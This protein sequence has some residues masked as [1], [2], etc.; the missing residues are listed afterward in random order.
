MAFLKGPFMGED[1]L[2]FP[3]LSI[4]FLLLYFVSENEKQAAAVNLSFN[5]E[6]WQG[7]MKCR[8]LTVPTPCPCWDNFAGGSNKSIV[9]SHHWT[10]STPSKTRLLYNTSNIHKKKITKELL[11]KFESIKFYSQIMMI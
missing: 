5:W 8:R 6:R 11:L 4:I 7:K 2:F 9:L 10:L 1:L 3:P